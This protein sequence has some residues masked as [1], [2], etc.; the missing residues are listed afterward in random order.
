V[1][2]RREGIPGTG[3]TASSVGLI[4]LQRENQTRLMGCEERKKKEEEA[5]R[6]K[7]HEGGVAKRSPKSILGGQKG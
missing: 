7:V 6:K 3:S 1:K 4:D 5:L 2:G